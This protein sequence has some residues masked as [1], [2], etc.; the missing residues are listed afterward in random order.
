MIKKLLS[1]S[2]IALLTLFSTGF[3]AIAQAAQLSVNTPVLIQSNSNISEATNRTG[4]IVDF[5]VVNPIKDSNGNVIIAANTPVKASIVR[6]EEK[7][8]IGRPT[9][10]T[11]SGFTTVATNGKPIVLNGS[12]N[13]KSV[14][15]MKRSIV[16]SA[17]LLPFFL[18]MKGAAVELPAGFQINVY[19]AG[20]YNF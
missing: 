16:L 3:D 15:R 13:K 17:L 11:I 20:D 1:I 18:L 10:L 4:D 14:S 7:K 19:P 9:N 12:I 5:H 2:L 8:R 6:L